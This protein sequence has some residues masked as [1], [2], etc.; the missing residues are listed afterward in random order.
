[1]RGLP[2]LAQCLSICLPMQQTAVQSL[3]GELISY[4]LRG[5]KRSPPPLLQI[6]TRES[7]HTSMMSP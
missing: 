1:M 3:L 2:Q 6:V 7:Q 4:T 5:N